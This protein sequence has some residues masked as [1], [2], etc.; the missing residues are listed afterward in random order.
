VTVQIEDRPLGVFAHE[1]GHCLG[2]ED[3]YDKDTAIKTGS[4]DIAAIYVGEWDLMSTPFRG[5]V[6]FSSYNKLKLGWIKPDQ[7]K[8]VSRG[9]T[10]LL[11]IDPLSLTNQ[12][13][14]ALKIILS[15]NAYYLVE[16]RQRIGFDKYLPINGV[17]I[18]LVDTTLSTGKVRVQD[19]T[20]QTNSLGD[21]AFG[22]GRNRNP[23]FKD[24][25]NDLAIVVLREVGLS[26]IILVT[27]ASG[28]YK[29]AANAAETFNNA[30]I[31][32]MRASKE[33]RTVGLDQANST[34]QEAAKAMDSCDFERAITLANEA[35]NLAEKATKPQVVTETTRPPS[36]VKSPQQI[37]SPAQQVGLRVDTIILAGAIIIISTI[38][39]ITVRRKWS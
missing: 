18:Y 13:I 10:Q 31:A 32:I 33:G 21:A 25:K 26:Y 36:E 19:A 6:H 30:S 5:C 22:I 39:G 16:V 17:L 9:Q 14:Y 29:L 2:L 38:I 27:K 24:E 37:P 4:S 3:L 8:T 23:I 7:L 11:K 20:P 15:R 28:D 34:L 1:L 35:K 12:S